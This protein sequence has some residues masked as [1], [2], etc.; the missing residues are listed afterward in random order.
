M[1]YS[2]ELIEEIRTKNDIVDVISGYVKLQKKG[3]TYFGLCPFHNERSPS[4]SVTPGKEMYY[5]FGCGA[6]GNVFTFLMEYENYTFPEALKALAQ[7]ANIPLPEEGEYSPEAKRQADL[8]TKLL[9]IQK[10]AGLYFYYQLRSERGKMAWDYLIKRGLTE[11]TIKRFGL[12]Y[13]NKTSDDLYLYLRQK[14]Y[15]DSL[16]K[17]SGLVTIEERGAHDKFWNRVMFPIMD[18]HG[19]VIGFGGRVMGEGEPKYLNSPETKLFDKS[20]NLY[21]M[22]YARISKRPNII[23]CEG[24]MDVIALHQAGF[25]N[26]VASLG[27]AFTSG[28]ASLL[29][30]YTKE[31]LL[32]YDSDGAG[33]KAA[34]RAIPILKEAGLSAKVVNLKPHK[35]PDEFIKNL[36]AEELQKKLDSAQNSFLYEV[37]VKQASY[38]MEDPEQKTEFFNEIAQMLLEFTQELERNNYIEAICRE[39]QISYESLRSLVNRY[40]YQL[41]GQPKAEIKR[42]KEIQDAKKKEKEDG[43]KKSQ[44]LLLTWMADDIRLFDKLKK[45]ISPKD[46]TEEFYHTVAEMLFEQYQKEKMVTPA[47]IISRFNTEKEQREAASLF[48]TSFRE[49][50]TQKE[51]EK[52]LNETIKKVKTNWCEYAGR[53]VTDLTELMEITQI[54]RSLQDLHISLD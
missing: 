22:N 6:G 45:I 54:K 26:A 48:N 15:S 36:G 3:S 19:H 21:G 23:I 35:D 42:T 9:E 12:G 37:S 38:H 4:F 28:Q 43:I 52:A 31:V 11:E 13:S 18:I 51:K 5:C 46:F 40:G 32:T 16:L 34:L 41:A 44:R 10:E 50:M 27:T 33:Q 8:K 53:Q 25:S 47:R 1:I 7:R 14:G 39:Y 20:R 2:D 49:E 24:Y 29:K 30:R 17:E